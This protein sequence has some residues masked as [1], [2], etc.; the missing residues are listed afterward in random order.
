MEHGAALGYARTYRGKR[1]CSEGSVCAS[2]RCSCPA[3][4]HP[5][6]KQGLFNADGIGSSHKTLRLCMLQFVDGGRKALEAAD[7]GSDQPGAHLPRDQ[8]SARSL[9]TF[10][11]SFITQEFLPEVY[12]TFR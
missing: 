8:G 2:F 3:N 9:R 10:L 7:A 11:E 4:L 12:V 6:A 5:H 1:Q